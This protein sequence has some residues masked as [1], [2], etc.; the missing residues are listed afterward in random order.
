M[1][2]HVPL[3]AFDGL[4]Q[5]T[6]VWLVFVFHVNTN[7]A[8]QL[9]SGRA[10]GV[11]IKG[12]FTPVTFVSQSANSLVVYLSALG[13]GAVVESGSGSIVV[14][15]W[16][17]HIYNVLHEQ[18]WLCP[19]RVKQRREAGWVVPMHC[20]RNCVS[21]QSTGRRPGRGRKGNRT[22]GATS[23]AA[24]AIH[25]APSSDALEVG[26]ASEAVE[27][28]GLG[29]EGLEEEGLEEEGL[30]D[31]EAAGPG[32]PPPKFNVPAK[33]KPPRLGGAKLGEDRVTFCVCMC[34]YVCVCM[35]LCVL[36]SVC[37]FAS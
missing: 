34:V 22:A 15:D 12:A 19:T 25:S 29:E 6:H 23:S 11:T 8:R 5:Y 9:Q 30:G 31:V 18:S 36:V 20:I 10:A 26:G 2:P 3:E 37:F 4:E 7:L 16:T 35:P 33:V 17:G 27:E 24:D 1:A 21:C 32:H 14:P 28:E 13:F